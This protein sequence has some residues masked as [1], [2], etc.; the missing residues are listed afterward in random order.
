MKGYMKRGEVAEESYEGGEV[1]EG[2]YDEERG[3][4]TIMLGGGMGYSKRGEV[5][6]GLFIEGRGCQRVT[7]Y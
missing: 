1:G 4:L 7:I 3:G 6:E 5:A 2:L